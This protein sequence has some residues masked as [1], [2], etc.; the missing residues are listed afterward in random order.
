M[1]IFMAILHPE[2]VEK[3][4]FMFPNRVIQFQILITENY[5]KENENI[6]QL[7]KKNSFNIFSNQSSSY[8]VSPKTR[9]AFT[10]FKSFTKNVLNCS[11]SKN[12]QALFLIFPWSFYLENLELSIK[13]ICY[14]RYWGL[15]ERIT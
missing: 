6:R 7:A 15:S 2:I 9:I 8:P 4:K 3:L 12:I 13:L 11:E 5:D 14:S 10:L 1:S